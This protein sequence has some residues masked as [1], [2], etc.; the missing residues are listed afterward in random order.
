MVKS[1]AFVARTQLYTPHVLKLI[2]S[3]RREFRT[4]KE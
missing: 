2:R 4:C 3:E 1:I